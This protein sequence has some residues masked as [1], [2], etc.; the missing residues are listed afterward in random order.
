MSGIPLASRRYTVQARIGGRWRRVSS[1][2]WRNGS[3][4]LLKPAKGKRYGT[5]DHRGVANV[6]AWQRRARYVTGL[7][8]VMLNPWPNLVLDDDT[9]WPEPALC[10]ALQRIG[11]RLRRLLKLREGTR[12]HARQAQ[13]YRQNMDPATG[14]PR[15]GRPLTARPG[16]S[17]HEDRDGNGY[18]EAADV[19]VLPG[20][21]NVG[22]FPGGRAA[23]AA[24]G[25]CFP[26]PGERWHVERGNT[27]RA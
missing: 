9:G 16:T 5:F 26:V 8:V 3:V 13:L 1:T 25:C 14:R 27:W 24:E 20:D 7:R 21:V 15:P 12:S 4:S 23:V 18:G 17:N 2:R 10:G 11:R 6:R 22:D 19:G